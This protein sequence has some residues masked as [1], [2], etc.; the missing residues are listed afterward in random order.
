VPRH[1]RASYPSPGSQGGFRCVSGGSLHRQA[2]TISGVCES[3]LRRCLQA[4][5]AGDLEFPAGAQ[6]GSKTPQALKAFR[7]KPDLATAQQ[8]LAAGN[9]FWNAGMFFWRAEVFGVAMRKYLP[10]TA[11]LL[12]SLPAVTSRDFAAQLARVYPRCENI[13]VDFGIMEKAAN[14]GIV[15]SLATDDIGW[16][17]L[18]SWNAVHEL[19]GRD[20]AGNALKT[21]TLLHQASG[22]YVQAPKGKM[23]ALV[24]VKDLVVVDTG[25]AL[26]VV[27]RDEA[28]SVGQIVKLLEQQKRSDLL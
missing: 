1:G 10:K 16:N 4:G 18:G 22:C 7:E 6:A 23:V 2:E 20:A 28:Q 25:D 21:P 8:F 11:A 3:G 17:D 5:C 12:S 26:L 14:D 9:F 27:H 15:Q 19:S 13:S 24:G